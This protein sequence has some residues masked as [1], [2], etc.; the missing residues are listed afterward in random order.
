MYIH[1]FEGGRFGALCEDCTDRYIDGQ[2]PPWKPDAIGRQSK[3]LELALR[4]AFL[5]SA[6]PKDVYMMMAAFLKPRD[7]P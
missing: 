6:A 4:P 2:G 5:P 3:M 7:Q 1:D